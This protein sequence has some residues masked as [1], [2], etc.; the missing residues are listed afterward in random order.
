M[1]RENPPT[2][3]RGALRAPRRLPLHANDQD[4][5]IGGP[6]MVGG[7]A[8][9]PG[10]W[11]PDAYGLPPRCP[12]EPLG[13]HGELIYCQDAI[14]QLHAVEPGKIGQKYIQMLFGARQGYLYWAWP[15][16]SAKA[17]VVGWRAEKVAEALYNGASTRGVFDAAD[18]VRGRGAWRDPEGGLIYHSGSSL[19]RS[20]ATV[21]EMPIGH[22]DGLFYPRRP[23]IPAPWS[24]RVADT[25]NPCAILFPTLQR[26]EWDR[27]DVDPILF[28]GW[29]AAALIG[30][31]LPWRPTAFVIGDRATGKST[32]QTL[33]KGVLG[34]ALLS[35]ADTTAAG[36]YQRVQ[37]DSLP[38]AVDELE[39]EV[40]SRK[41][42]A[43]VRLARLAASGAMMFRG[44]ADH[45]GT[46]FRAQSCFLF[47]SINPPPLAPQDVS[48]MVI[49]RLRKLPPGVYAKMAPT[50]VDGDVAGRMLLRRLMD[51]WPRFDRVFGEYRAALEA[52]GHDGRGQ[53]TLGVL[54]ACAHLAIG[55]ELADHLGLPMV[56]DL[57][58]W[59]KLLET[60]SML[61]YE[62]LTSNWYS[63]V[64]YLFTAR[65]EAWRGGLRHTVGQLVEDLMLDWDRP[66]DAPPPPAAVTLPDARR[67]LAQAGVG[68][69][70]PGTL[71]EPPDQ[72]DWILAVPHES[73]L[74]GDLYRNT[75]W[76]G[77]GGG[78]SVWKSALRQAPPEVVINN[79]ERNRISINGVQQRCTLIR[80]RKFQGWSG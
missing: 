42:M 53:D 43:V 78:G 70:P 66:A 32:L 75:P 22:L 15:R 71:H 27:P 45:V 11:V 21:E 25:A 18:R 19:W 30:G 80:V 24:E 1:P 5:P 67:L 77:F 61:E 34:D 33:A 37:R 39:A 4:P 60:S 50:V 29:L 35:T 46:E 73:Q 72:R 2:N 20:G 56:D 6:R 8:I 13:M 64:K 14:G 10:E 31:A 17:K 16:Y 3:V 65:V 59:S 58:Q 23:E 51:G 79:P 54:L 12:V 40:D 52:G 69:L 36:I 44:G 48:R 68:I 38:I 57:R 7:V 62:D 74:V 49:L 55:E 76:A 47:S 26:W 41:T 63:A 9:K 28:L